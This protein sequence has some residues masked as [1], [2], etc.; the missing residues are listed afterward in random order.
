VT[1]SAHFKSGELQVTNS[2]I[3]R[4]ATDLDPKPFYLDLR[5]GPRFGWKVSAAGFWRPRHIIPS[6]RQRTAGSL[7]NHFKLGQT[8]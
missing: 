5:P 7:L 1:D 4:F 2:D 3:K 8:N 6:V